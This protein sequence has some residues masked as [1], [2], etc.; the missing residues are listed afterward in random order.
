[1]NEEQVFGIIIKE[2]RSERSL[3]QE[4][5]AKKSNLDRTYISQIE[6]G[7]KSP[8]L[9][10]VFKIAHALDVLPSELLLRVEERLGIACTITGGD[11]CAD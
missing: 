11:S 8:T 2:I 1:M 3:S 10:T 4:I 6:T 7:K 5:L 9:S